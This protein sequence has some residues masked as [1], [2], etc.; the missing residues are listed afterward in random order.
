MKILCKIN[1]WTPFP[2]RRWKAGEAVEMS[3]EL[4]ERLLRNKNFAEVSETKPE[5]KSEVKKDEFK[6]RKARSVGNRD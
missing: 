2:E 3:K 5:A 6:H 1:C 4:A